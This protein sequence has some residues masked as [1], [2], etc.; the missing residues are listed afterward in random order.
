MSSLSLS[1]SLMK[2]DRAQSPGEG[3]AILSGSAKFLRSGDQDGNESTT[4]RGAG[5]GRFW[6][7]T[8]TGTYALYNIVQ[9]QFKSLVKSDNKLER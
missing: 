9:I 1:L 5:W 3:E 6:S 7:G 4:K 2:M 8:R